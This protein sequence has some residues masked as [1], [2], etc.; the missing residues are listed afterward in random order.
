MF[1]KTF[2]C[3]QHSNINQTP[4]PKYEFVNIQIVSLIYDLYVQ[5]I[6]SNIQRLNSV[7][8]IWMWQTQIKKTI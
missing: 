7:I 4:F 5:P 3:N 6:L 1:N 2:H 8:Q